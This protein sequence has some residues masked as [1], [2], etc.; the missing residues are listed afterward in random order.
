MIKGDSYKFICYLDDLNAKGTALALYGYAFRFF[1][2]ISRVTDFKILA[3]YVELMQTKTLS[4]NEVFAPEISRFAD[5]TLMDQVKL[6]ICFENY[7]KGILLEKKHIVHNIK[8]VKRSEENKQLV[9]L[10]KEQNK[11]PI[12]IKEYKPL[13]EFEYDEISKQNTLKYLSNNTLSYSTLLEKSNYQKLIQIDPKIIAIL[14]KNRDRRNSLH[15]LKSTVTLFGKDTVDDWKLLIDYVNDH[16]VEAYNKLSE[17][18][19]FP[20]NNKIAIIT[21]ANN[22]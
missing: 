21:T 4:F 8:K 6:G 20:K 7:M 22:G 12:C 10:K 18:L 1:S 2:Q 3:D 5:E 15:F 17:E 14:K 19:D 11:R 9:N 13:D 16:I